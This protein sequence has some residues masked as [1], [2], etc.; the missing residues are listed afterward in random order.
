MASNI[1]KYLIGGT[2]QG[3][4]EG[5]GI[6][7]RQEQYQQQMAKEK[8]IQDEEDKRKQMSIAQANQKEQAK[9]EEAKKQSDIISRILAEGINETVISP[10]QGQL[11]DIQRQPMVN[12]SKGSTQQSYDDVRG[13]GSGDINPETNTSQSFNTKDRRTTDLTPKDSQQFIPDSDQSKLAL[14]SQLKSPM[15]MLNY[16][17]SQKK[18][19]EEKKKIRDIKEYPDKQVGRDYMG[20]E[21]VLK[22]YDVTK[23]EINPHATIKYEKIPDP[24]GKSHRDAA[25]NK[26]LDMVGYNSQYGI[27]EK[28]PDGKTLQYA[29]KVIQKAKQSRSKNVGDI[30]TPEM[31]KTLGKSYNVMMGKVADYNLL[32]GK[33]PEKE[34][35]YIF[36]D[37]KG[38]RI[39]K[40]ASEY[41]Q[42]LKDR[43]MDIYHDR[44]REVEEIMLAASPKF[45]EWIDGATE[46]AGG[47]TPDQENFLKSLIKNHANG[48][49][50]AMDYQDGL[51]YS[52][53][54]HMQN[55]KFKLMEILGK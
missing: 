21:V 25:G 8:L 44:D 15:P 18:D 48:S 40:T 10:L 2:N 13:F 41:Q 32:R 39:E 49:L 30:Y 51:K 20:T 27:Y 47:N 14:A 3:F 4:G 16:L 54:A 23:G 5:L 35:K 42:M 38:E 43:E 37:K 31:S 52:M 26:V 55:P 24:R 22:N 45:V 12:L 53:F 7:N 28:G 29:P 1:W 11:S 34:G 33:Q 50:S 6:A 46:A 9:A 19:K 17:R 36:H